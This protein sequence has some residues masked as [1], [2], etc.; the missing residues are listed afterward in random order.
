MLDNRHMKAAD[1]RRQPSAGHGVC[2]LQH[3]TR[4][5]RDRTWMF[6][7]HRLRLR[8]LD[9]GHCGLC[10]TFVQWD[11]EGWPRTTGHPFADF[12]GIPAITDNSYTMNVRQPAE[13]RCRVTAAARFRRTNH[14]PPGSDR[15]VW[16]IPVAPPEASLSTCDE[17]ELRRTARWW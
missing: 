5:T 13:P 16:K 3:H 17:T 10:S 9:K 11:D 2:Q 6:S 1:S 15:A 7:S 14:R 12:H 8:G 4:T